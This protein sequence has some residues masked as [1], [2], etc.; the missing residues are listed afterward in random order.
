MYT[1]KP[2]FMVE[3]DNIV[4]IKKMT[5]SSSIV[6]V[7]SGMRLERFNQAAREESRRKVLLGSYFVYNCL[8]VIGYKEE[9]C[10][11]AFSIE[12]AYLIELPIGKISYSNSG[13]Y[14]ALS[15]S[16]K[17]D[18][19]VDIEQYKDRPIEVYQAFLKSSLLD[20]KKLKYSFYRGWIEKEIYYKSHIS[21]GI[22]IMEVGDY[23][24]G[25]A[26]SNDAAVRV[27]EL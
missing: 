6:N 20:L 3:Y 1:V 4:F 15:F 12:S 14:H 26:F 9:V 24:L 27:I 22:N 13:D 2:S 23:M 5:L 11:R 8:K 18:S 21:L 7:L 17:A 19:A 10:A 25:Y 16:I